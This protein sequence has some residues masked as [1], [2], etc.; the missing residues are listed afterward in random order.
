[1]ALIPNNEDDELKTT[2]PIDYNII[3]LENIRNTIKLEPEIY[4]QMARMPH[5]A[6]IYYS[7]VQDLWLLT[8]RYAPKTEQQRIDKILEKIYNLTRINTNRDV[9]E[10][11][12][13]NTRYVFDRILDVLYR[14]GKLEKNVFNIRG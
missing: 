14:K 2:L 11:I 6:N 9:S 7:H 12:Y 13:Q 1:M 3:I 4:F 5:L 8:K 10:I